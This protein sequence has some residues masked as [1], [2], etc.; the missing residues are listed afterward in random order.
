MIR[1]DRTLRRL[2][3][4]CGLS[5]L[6]ANV[7]FVQSA[8]PEDDFSRWEKSIAAFEKQK[9]VPRGG[10]LFVGSSSIRGWDLKE[11]FPEFTTI[12]RGFGGSQVADSVHFADR[13]IF[14]YRPKVVVLYAGD[15]DISKG[16]T[17]QRV[18]TDFEKF[19]ATIHAELPQTR[20]LFL[21]IKPSLKRWN[22]V[23]KMQE[24][25]R[26]IAKACQADTRL[27]SVNTFDVLLGKDGKPDPR[28][29]REDGLHLNADGYQ[30]W[31]TVLK[32]QIHKQLREFGRPP[33]R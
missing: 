9:N 1:T 2:A 3:L 8:E 33:V 24:A 20:I 23:G 22:L 21:P 11:S 17:P 6:V 19:V 26:L 16:K 7:R 28:F 27:V 10:V 32:P 30:T 13:L 14:P 29:F 25:N 15:N 12:N 31:T 5:A 4:F 18:F